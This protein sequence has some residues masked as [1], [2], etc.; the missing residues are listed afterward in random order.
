MPPEAF[1]T[2]EGLIGLAILHA[3]W[4]DLAAAAVAA[5]AG[6]FV[7]SHEARH[8]LFLAALGVVAIGSPALAVLQHVSP[9]EGRASAVETSIGVAR[10]E[11]VEAPDGPTPS[12]PATTPR[13]A[14]TGEGPTALA[15][16]FR[17][18]AAALGAVK[19]YLAAGWALGVAGS[20]AILLV[21]ALS[22]R[23]LVAHSA[24]VAAWERRARAMS[25]AFRLRRPPAVRVH[26]RVA[27]PCLA[28]VLRP[29]VLLPASWLDAEPGEVDAVLAHELAH[30][31]RLDHVANLAQRAVEAFLFFHPA[32]LW[33]SRSA[34]RESEPC[35]D[36]LAARLTGDPLALARAL[37]YAARRPPAGPGPLR[38]GLGLPVSGDRSTLLP[39]IQELLGMKPPRPRL[40]LWPFAALPAA[41][42]LAF[43]AAAVTTAEDSVHRDLREFHNAVD[44]WRITSPKLPAPEVDIRSLPEA[45]RVRLL[46]TPPSKLSHED[47]V[48]LVRTQ[49]LSPGDAPGL[50]REELLKFASP[51]QVCFVVRSIQLRTRR[52]DAEAPGQASLIRTEL[53]PHTLHAM[54]RD[55]EVSSFH[56]PRVTA[57]EQATL[58]FITG[59]EIASPGL[60]DLTTA[61]DH[62]GPIGRVV[63]R[64]DGPIEP[65]D[66]K[67]VLADRLHGVLGFQI[68]TARKRWGH[69]VEI[70]YGAAVPERAVHDGAPRT[71]A[72]RIL[73]NVPEGSGI[74]FDSGI[75]VVAGETDARRIK[76]LLLVTPVHIPNE[77]DEEAM[78][79]PVVDFPPHPD[80]KPS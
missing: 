56:A 63:A 74:L 77:E 9:G 27:E 80:R 30:A 50:S 54:S 23:R 34:R 62:E 68:K 31:R 61:G 48:M 11:V 55:S 37:E 72:R 29:V 46:T 69:A 19:P 24:P 4:L 76:T 12:D 39:R 7:A 32:A 18:A 16:L 41:V 14:E 3:A 52:P 25:R 65:G 75:E 59:D 49:P 40:A 47:L 71:I 70:R 10:G 13:V 6:R 2:A 79:G 17:R 28:G 38:P 64:L 21:G 1:A 15:T 45:D 51:G 5:I 53:L 58:T 73:M 78:N 66:P 36:A 57:F 35:A 33:L 20:G 43:L 67:L 26:D 22:L 42:V 60:P 8:A 44:E